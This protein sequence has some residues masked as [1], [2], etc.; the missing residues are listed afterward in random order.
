MNPDDDANRA[1]MVIDSRQPVLAYCLKNTRAVEGST[2]PLDPDRWDRNA[3]EIVQ[4]ADELFNTGSPQRG[5]D[6]KIVKPDPI[7]CREYIARKKAK[8]E[9]ERNAVALRKA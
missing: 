6:G 1:L 3:S 8:A 5:L 2:T 9:A 7:M 4:H